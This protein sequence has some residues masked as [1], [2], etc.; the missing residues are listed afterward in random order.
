MSIVHTVP[1]MAVASSGYSYVVARLSDELVRNGF[2]SSVATVGSVDTSVFR[3]GVRGFPPGPGPARLF[4]SAELRRWL[5]ASARSGECG[6]IHAHS[7]WAMPSIYPSGVRRRTGCPFVLSPHGTLAP[8]AF[9]SGSWLKT[10]F[11]QLLQRPALGRAACLHATADAEY[12]DIRSKGISSP[13][14]VIPNGVDIPEWV[15]TRDLPRRTVLF[16]SRV[17]PIKQ[18]ERLLAAWSR[19]ESRFSDWDLEIAGADYD[20]P[21]YLARMKQLAH[22]LGLGR[23]RF[24]GE[25]VGG[26]KWDAFRGADLYVLPSKA[27][28]FGVTIAE[29]LAA[30]T[31]VVATKGAPWAELPLHGAGWWIEDDVESVAQ[32]LESAMSLPRDQLRQMGRAG[33]TWVEGAFGWPAIASQFAQLYEWVLFGADPSAKP[34]FVRFD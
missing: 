4:S 14:A 31:P 26:R 25:V 33:R 6:L 5:L 11:W 21:G 18:P 12:R 1:S 15:P 20:S 8:A 22:R 34:S 32:A 23:V 30:G 9:S 10:P 17:H 27:E 7:L 24:L 28:N 13:V 2:A 29:A 19:L 16:L 3:S